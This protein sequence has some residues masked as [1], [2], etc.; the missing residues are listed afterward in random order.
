M[1]SLRSSARILGRTTVVHP[2]S[3]W[4]FPQ[5]RQWPTQPLFRM[6]DS[7]G[8]ELASL[9]VHLTRRGRGSESCIC[10]VASGRYM[11]KNST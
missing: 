2:T 4:M 3:L 5:S 8:L 1:L 10:A 9:R 6:A 7:D 11:P